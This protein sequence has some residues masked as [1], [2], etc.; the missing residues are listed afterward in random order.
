MSEK[1]F[2]ILI[3]PSGKGDV[4]LNTTFRKVSCKDCGY[5]RAQGGNMCD[6]CEEKARKARRQ[7]REMMR[8]WNTFAYGCANP[9][10]SFKHGTFDP[11]DRNFKHLLDG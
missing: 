7:Y 11:S 2:S 1:T 8:G 9:V 5:P 4:E 6:T 10:H 3:D